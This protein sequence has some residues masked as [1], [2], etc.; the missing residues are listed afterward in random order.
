MNNKEIAKGWQT[1]VFSV[2]RPPAQ[3]GGIF[4][5]GATAHRSGDGRPRSSEFRERIH[6][7]G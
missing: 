6:H 5:R 3:I 1:I 4:V 2:N 7:F